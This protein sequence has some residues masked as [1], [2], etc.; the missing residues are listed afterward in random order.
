[1]CFVLFE[2]ILNFEEYEFFE[3]YSENLEKIRSFLRVSYFHLYF[4]IIFKILNLRLLYIAKKRFE[5]FSK[6][7][8]SSSTI[9]SKTFFFFKNI[10]KLSETFDQRNPIVQQIFRERI[11]TNSSPVSLRQSSRR[12][13]SIP[14]QRDPIVRNTIILSPL[15]GRDIRPS[16]GIGHRVFNRNTEINFNLFGWRHGKTLATLERSRM[17][18]RLSR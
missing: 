6:K 8:F 3:I 10:S 12:K 11:P 9:S 14:S 4:F 2:F 5:S 16:V 18:V 17:P 7:E 15:K 1:M 13:F